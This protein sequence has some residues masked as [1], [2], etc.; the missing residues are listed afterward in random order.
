MSFTRKLKVEDSSN[1][2]HIAYDLDRLQMLVVFSGGSR[3]VYSNVGPRDF[4][5][6]CAAESVGN[7]LNTHIKPNFSAKKVPGVGEPN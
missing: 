7:Y 5:M 4:G 6:L 3:Y 1:V 2:T